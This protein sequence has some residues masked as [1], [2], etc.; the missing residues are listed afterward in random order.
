MQTMIQKLRRETM[1]NTEPTMQAD[2]AFKPM[3]LPSSWVGS[4][5]HVKNSTISFAHD[6]VSM[7]T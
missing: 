1:E 7:L 5:A 2:M 6:S 3:S 4:D